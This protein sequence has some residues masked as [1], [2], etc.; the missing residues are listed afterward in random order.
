[1]YRHLHSG[2][3]RYVLHEGI[4]YT[5]AISFWLR[6]TVVSARTTIQRE[7]KALIRSLGGG[8]GGGGET[9]SSLGLR[10]SGPGVLHCMC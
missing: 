10:Q 4:D 5:V 2:S 6:C 3:L 7:I 8:G 1:M 9:K